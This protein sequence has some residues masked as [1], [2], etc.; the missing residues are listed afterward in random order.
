MTAGPPFD[1]AE[2]LR[3]ILEYHSR[4]YYGEDRTE[5]SDE[6]FDGM[7]RRLRDLEEAWP[8]LR[9]PDSPTSRV[10]APPVQSFGA[11][12]HDPPMLSLDNVFSEEEFSAFEA[13]VMRELGLSAPPMYSLEPKLDGLAVSLVYTDGVLSRGA[14]RGDGTTGEDVTANVRT[15]KSVPLRLSGAPDGALDVRGE[16][17]FPKASFESLNRSR[18][19]SGERPFANPRNAASGS[20]RQLD[21]RV[22]AGRPLAFVAYSCVPPPPSAGCQ[23][24]LLAWLAGLGMPVNPGNRVCTGSREV[25]QARDDLEKGRDGLPWEIDGMVVKLDDF[26]LCARMGALSRAPRWAVAWKFNPPEAATRVLS[27]RVGVGRTGRLTPVASLEPVRVG[28][29]SVSRATLHNEDELRRKDVRPGDMV[30]VRR[31]GEVIPEVVRSLGNPGGT[32]SEPF[33]FPSS[34]PVCRGPVVRP[35][36]E[37]AHRCINPS[38]PA[39]LKEGVLHWASRE[40]MDIEGL[41]DRLAERLVDLGLVKD[42]ADIYGLDGDALSRV[43][44][45]GERSSARLIG[46]ISASRHA[47]LERVLAGLGI[48]GVGRVAASALSAAFGSMEAVA[49]A[50]AERLQGVEGIGPVLAGSLA[51]FFGSEVTGAVVQRLAEAGVEMGSRRSTPSSGR[52]SG[53]VVVFTGALSMSREDA[54][55]LAEQAGARVTDSI[56]ARTGLLVA[57]PGAGSKLERARELGVE[58]VDEAGFLKRIGAR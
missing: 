22:T 11:V 44:R 45:M 2:Q 35:E 6:E 50:G 42:L 58:T 16:V 26:A 49:A 10:G 41:G 29:V 25:L 39:R 33:E 37:A 7:M 43:D 30:I 55:R 5:I 15:I 53:I 8:E 57:G 56:S 40:A 21:S 1:E 52:L 46:K 47:G 20:L 9:T 18:E 14:T 31:A 36:G 19:A 48:P 17:L 24:E 38:C 51:A 54:R 32:R 13:R 23:S 3:R 12:I 27:I 4:L 34:C 28:G